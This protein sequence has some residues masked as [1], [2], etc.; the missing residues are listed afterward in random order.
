MYDSY[1]GASEEIDLAAAQ[2]ENHLSAFF[3]HQQFMYMLQCHHCWAMMKPDVKVGVTGKRILVIGS[4]WPW[5]E[6]VLLAR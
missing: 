6:V 4:Q 1:F 3:L 5:L 2:V